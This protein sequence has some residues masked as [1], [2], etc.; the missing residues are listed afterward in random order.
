MAESTGL[1]ARIGAPL[2]DWEHTR[3]SIERILTT[4]LGSRVMR[5][6]L[7]SELPDMIDRKI[8]Q[9]NVLALY[10]AAA[11]AIHRSAADGG[12]PR[13]RMRRGRL[14][15]AEPTG[16]ALDLFGTFFPRGH[17]GDFSIAE[18]ASIRVVLAMA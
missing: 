15:K 16:V 2:S 11:I 14:S 9:R 4:P 7:G 5:R 6:H 12:E 17:L 3:Q 18:D 1:D 10:A 13:F 8:V